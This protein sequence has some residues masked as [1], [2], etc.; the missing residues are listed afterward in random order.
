[1]FGSQLLE[2][3]PD[4]F[5]VMRSPFTG[6]EVVTVPALKPDWAVIHVQEADEE[7][8]ARISGS[9]FQDVLMSRAAKKTILTTERLVSGQSFR[10]AGWSTSIPHFLVAAVVEC[11]GGAAPGR[12]WPDYQV[13]DA[14]M[15]AYL[16][17]VRGGKDT[18]RDYLEQVQ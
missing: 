11:P 2:A 6:E 4:F 14:G 10:E 8:N 18:L 15:K 17:A 9:L 3:R 12:C 16:Q 13:D 7:G 5:K 1:M